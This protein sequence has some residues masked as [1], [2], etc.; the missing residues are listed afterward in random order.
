MYSTG[1]IVQNERIAELTFRLA[2]ETEERL[3]LV[4]AG[5]FAMLRLPRRSDPLLGRPLAVYR[6][7][8]HRLEVVYLVVG[9]M[10][11]RL[12]EQQNGNT[13]EFWLPLG[14]GF[15]ESTA[16][17]TIMVAGGIG[18]TPFLMLAEKRDLQNPA[19]Y[20]LLYGAR[21]KSRIACMDDF[22]RTGIDVRIATDDGSEGH[23]G[24]STDLIERVY[25]PGES[26]R[27]LCCGPKPMLYVVFKIAEKL[28]LPCY[29]SLETPMS[30]GL[31]ICYGCVVKY[32]DNP[33]TDEWDYRRTCKDGPVF[34]AY[35]LRWDD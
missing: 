13:L 28:G 10:T 31:G 3:P 27:L 17:H 35:R 14:N 11:E 12:A 7:T 2:L 5:Q 23:H 20:T 21:T 9:K 1:I 15:P 18:Q 25:R 19:R 34:N 26:T 6:C 24:F 22:R 4:N 30:C 32:K 33:D 8:E 29:V 16:E